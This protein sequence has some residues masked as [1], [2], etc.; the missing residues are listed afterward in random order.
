M[1]CRRAQSTLLSVG[2]LIIHLHVNVNL[3]ATL[4]LLQL[5]KPA[6]I[7]I[8]LFIHLVLGNLARNVAASTSR[9]LIQILE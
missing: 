2:S 4:L 3:L 1:T 9:L 8:L 7:L 5:T 6:Y